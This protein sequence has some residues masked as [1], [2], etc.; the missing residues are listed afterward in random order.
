MTTSTTKDLQSSSGGHTQPPLPKTR[1]FVDSNLIS[2]H[3]T[4]SPSKDPEFPPIIGAC[5]C[6]FNPC[7]I[8]LVGSVILPHLH[9][10]HFTTV[11]R[12]AIK[13]RGF[14]KDTFDKLHRMLG[15][16]PSPD[17]TDKEV[18]KIAHIPWLLG[19]SYPS[20]PSRLEVVIRRAIQEDTTF[21][22]DERQHCYRM[23]GMDDGAIARRNKHRECPSCHTP[24]GYRTDGGP[25]Y[26]SEPWLG[27]I[28]P[29]T[30]KHREQPW[31]ADIRNR[32]LARRQADPAP[33]PSHQRRNA[34]SIPR[35]P[36]RDSE[37]LFGEADL[38]LQV[39]ESGLLDD[40]SWEF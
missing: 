5:G 16:D 28:N 14:D 12:N 29:F 38:G 9:E 8:G 40:G 39:L 20:L 4:N 33:T 35:R 6:Q 17:E 11:M 22:E 26:V 19:H 3:E 18:R 27:P 30:G 13:K 36:A 21:S 7:N 15:I 1:A 23:L 31:Q 10:P 2:S 24:E 37:V 25:G 34:I 32:M